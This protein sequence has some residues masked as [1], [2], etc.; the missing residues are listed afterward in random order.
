MRPGTAEII[1]HTLLPNN[2]D[3]VTFRLTYW[4]AI[5]GELMTHRVASRCAKSS[6][7]IPIAKTIAQVWHDPYGPLHWG[8]NKAG[9]Q[10]GAEL[11]GFSLRLAHFLWKLAGRLMCIFAWL[12]MKMGGAKQWGNRILE[13]WQ[14]MV[15]V[16]TFANFDKGNWLELRDHPDAQPEFQQLAMCMRIAY[17]ASTPRQATE[18]R[19]LTTSWH[20]PFVTL[21]ERGDTVPNCIKMSTARCARASYDNYDGTSV[22]LIKDVALYDRLVGAKP[23][24]ASPTEHQCT[25]NPLLRND[26]DGDPVYASP[27]LQG[28]LTGTVQF[29][30]LLERGLVEMNPHPAIAAPIAV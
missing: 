6:R 20:L 11:T 24:H 16:F 17:Q 9:M 8:T 25:D 21:E 18:E 12:I 22:T 27:K 19:N 14:A 26:S 23:W 29:R 5:H 1:E 7:A 28:N 3:V 4:R 30:K 15:S 10:A 2:V 13:P